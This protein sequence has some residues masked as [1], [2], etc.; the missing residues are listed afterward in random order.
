MKLQQA[1]NI[2]AV[3]DRLE[4]IIIDLNN[5]LYMLECKVIIKKT[6]KE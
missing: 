3:F 2:M 5:R 1:E 6:D 4:R